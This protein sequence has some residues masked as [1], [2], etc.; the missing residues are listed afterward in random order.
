MKKYL[1]AFIAALA[2]T[3]SFAQDGNVA[4]TAAAIENPGKAMIEFDSRV[5]NFGMLNYGSDGSH[6]YKFTN[7]G[8]APLIISNVKPSCGCTVADGWPKEAVPPGESGEIKIK[9]DTKR[10]GT[11]EKS[12]TVYS[13]AT[14]S[15]VRLMIKGQVKANTNKP[16]IGG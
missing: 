4:D 8:D 10:S 3:I 7:T 2:F 14:E 6:V 1:L 16:K 13:N 9:Y 5:K 11:F 12:I 15:A